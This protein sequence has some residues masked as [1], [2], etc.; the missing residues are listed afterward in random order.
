MGNFL[1]RFA[2][3]SEVSPWSLSSIQLKLIKIGAKVVS[4]S[5]RRIFQM[6]E[7]AVP[8]ALFAALLERIRCLATAPT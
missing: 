3:P 6:A 8:E 1:R 5:R 2:L 4:H 7:V